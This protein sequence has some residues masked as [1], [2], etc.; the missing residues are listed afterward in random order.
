MSVWPWIPLEKKDPFRRF[1]R[2]QVVMMIDQLSVG[3][4]A[5]SGPK[6]QEARGSVL[7]FETFDTL[8][9][10]VEY[11]AEAM[12]TEL[13]HGRAGMSVGT[14]VTDDD[15]LLTA[16]IVRAHLEGVEGDDRPPFTLFPQYYDWL[17]F[18][19]NLHR[20]AVLSSV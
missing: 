11:F 18:V 10:P 17:W 15:P 8:A 4:E 7:M 3:A 20:A 13:E 1:S 19:E 2:D 16:Q 5:I 9:D 12:N 14:N 6:R